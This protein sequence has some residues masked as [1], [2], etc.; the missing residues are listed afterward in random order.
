MMINQ[1]ITSKGIGKHIPAFSKTTSFQLIIVFSIRRPSIG[2]EHRFSIFI[3]HWQHAT[4]EVSQP[5]F[6]WAMF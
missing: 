5:D 6:A 2:G 4:T 3:C 1:M